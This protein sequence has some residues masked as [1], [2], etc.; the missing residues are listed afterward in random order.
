MCCE[1]EALFF[2]F[3]IKFIIWIIFIVGLINIE[4]CAYCISSENKKRYYI[5]NSSILLEDKNK[6]KFSKMIEN[7][8]VYID[9]WTVNSN[10][11]LQQYKDNVKI[12]L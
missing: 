11:S 8:D 12:I 9:G 10:V 5:T 2:C 3:K 4:N 1:R 6:I 7:G